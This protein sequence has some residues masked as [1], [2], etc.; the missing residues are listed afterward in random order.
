MIPTKPTILTFWQKFV[1]LQWKMLLSSGS[2]QSESHAYASYPSEWLL[3]SRGIAY[4]IGV[5]NNAQIHLLGNP[6]LWFT[7]SLGL[8]VHGAVLVFYLLRRRRNC[9]DIDE[10]KCLDY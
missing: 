10:G 6:A 8:A 4:W 1:E 3:L 2:S 7:A 9:F 5:G